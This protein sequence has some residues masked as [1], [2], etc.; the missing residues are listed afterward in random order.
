MG[1]EQGPPRFKLTHYT[2]VSVGLSCETVATILAPAQVSDTTPETNRPWTTGE[3]GEL[4]DLARLGAH[5]VAEALGRS[6]SRAA[7]T[8]TARSVSLRV[9]GQRRGRLSVAQAIPM[10]IGPTNEPLLCPRC[11]DG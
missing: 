5:A 11:G 9:P 2:L 3:V 1:T 7:R 10:G 8:L 6:P 4:R